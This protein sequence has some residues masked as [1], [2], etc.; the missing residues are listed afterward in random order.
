MQACG[1]NIHT[2]CFNSW[3]QS[4]Q[5]SGAAVTCVYC[6]A[7]WSDAEIKAAEA[8]YLNLRPFSAAHA[9]VDTS[10][11]ALYGDTSGWIRNRGGPS[12]G[13]ANLWNAGRAFL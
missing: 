1:N 13:Q 9:G 5:R 11:E 10:L 12:R 8:E 7:K 6:R 2:E 3:R 4:K